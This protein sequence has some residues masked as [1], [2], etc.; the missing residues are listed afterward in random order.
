M[1]FVISGAGKKCLV[2]LYGEVNHSIAGAHMR[3]L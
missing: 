3:A 2:E 1:N